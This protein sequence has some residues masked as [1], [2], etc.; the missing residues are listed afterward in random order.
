MARFEVRC[1]AYVTSRPSRES[2]E[3]LVEQIEKV[4]ACGEQHEIVEV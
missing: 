1:A 4:G 3:R 2:A